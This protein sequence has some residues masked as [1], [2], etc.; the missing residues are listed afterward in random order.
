MGQPVSTPPG[1]QWDQHPRAGSAPPVPATMRVKSK[2]FFTDLRCTWL[3]SVAKPTYSLSSCRGHRARGTRDTA[4]PPPT[5]ESPS[6]PP[7]AEG[8]PGLD[9]QGMRPCLPKTFV[10]AGWECPPS[11]SPSPHGRP[12]SPRTRPAPRRSRRGPAAPRGSAGG[13]GWAAGAR[14]C[15]AGN[16]RAESGRRAW[17]P[18]RR[19]LRQ[20]GPC[21]RCPGG[22]RAPAGSPGPPPSWSCQ[23]VGNPAGTGSAQPRPSPP[24]GNAL[25]G[26]KGRR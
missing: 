2:P 6:F 21:P 26:D 20:G 16:P 22:G 19:W 7:P 1:Q 4:S 24:S 10:C 3:G 23:L 15:A 14:R 13:W 12:P 9:F 25:S 18:S 8:F 11:R 17:R 5:L